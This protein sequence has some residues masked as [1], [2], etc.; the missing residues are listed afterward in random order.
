[1]FLLIGSLYNL[2]IIRKSSEASKRKKKEIYE[3]EIKVLN[4]VNT[5]QKS[6]VTNREQHNVAFLLNFRR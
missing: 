5:F 6:L 4:E 1:M 2:A 3:K